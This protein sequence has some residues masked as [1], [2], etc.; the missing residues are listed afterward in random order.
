MAKS[1]DVANFFI[2]LAQRRSANDAGDLMTNLRLQKLIYFAQGWHLAR[3]SKPLFDAPLM[4]W[5]LGPVEPQIYHNF[6]E[7]GKNGISKAVECAP[8]AFTEQE[9]ELL[10]DIAREYDGY[11]TSK[12][13]DFTHA[14]GAPWSNTAK[15]A[16]ISQDEMRKYFADSKRLASFDDILD[17]YPVEVL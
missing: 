14:P 7:Y 2:E 8:D 11:S 16:E 12:L 10:L 1:S 3:F 15:R 9:Y 5:S 6:S 4:A 13:V 17:G